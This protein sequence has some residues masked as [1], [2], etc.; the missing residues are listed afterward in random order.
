[1]SET[2]QVQSVSKMQSIV[3]LHT[4]TQTLCSSWGSAFFFF[5]LSDFASYC[6]H[7]CH[8]CSVGWLVGCLVLHCRRMLDA[9]FVLFSSSDSSFP[10]PPPPFL[11]PP[12]ILLFFFPPSLLTQLMS[13]LP[14]RHNGQS[15]KRLKT[16]SSSFENGCLSWF[17]MT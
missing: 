4:H 6:C 17:A 15:K 14:F 12:T 5:G 9:F 16:A 8:Y 2:S 7:C 11:F 1:M 3:I 10:P 13:A